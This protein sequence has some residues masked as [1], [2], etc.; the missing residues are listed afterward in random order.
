MVWLDSATHHVALHILFLLINTLPRIQHK[1]HPRHVTQLLTCVASQMV[2][3][4]MKRWLSSAGP[5]FCSCVRSSS[6]PIASV[7]PCMWEKQ[8]GGW[9]DVGSE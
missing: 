7:S 9:R 6:L 1:C 8:V 5:Y 3:M 2:S 4:T